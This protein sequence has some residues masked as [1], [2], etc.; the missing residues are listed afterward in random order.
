LEYSCFLPLLSLRTCWFPSQLLHINY[1]Q[2]AKPCTVCD[3]EDESDMVPTLI[4][5]LA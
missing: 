3:C 1:V 4:I 2:E 5:I